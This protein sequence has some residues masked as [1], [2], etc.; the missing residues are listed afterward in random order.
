MRMRRRVGIF[1]FLLTEIHFCWSETSNSRLALIKDGNIYIGVLPDG[2][3]TRITDYQDTYRWPAVHGFSADGRKILY[4]I[5]SDEL[6][7]EK[8]I[9][10]VHPPD[11]NYFVMGVDGSD[12]RLVFSH[13]AYGVF[14]LAPDGEFVASVPCDD[15]GC[16]GSIEII[17][18]RDGATVA[19]TPEWDC[20]PT[21]ETQVMWS[22]DSK[23]IFYF[24]RIKEYFGFIEGYDQFFNLSHD[25]L[26]RFDITSS[27]SNVIADN[28]FLNG[29]PV[30]LLR[31]ASDKL[32]A[33]GSSQPIKS[34][35]PR[36][37]GIMIDP[38]T[39]SSQRM[40]LAERPLSLDPDT[41]K[42]Y[43]VDWASRKMSIIDPETGEGKELCKIETSA[44][45]HGLH[46]VR[47]NGQI[48]FTYPIEL[49]PAS[50]SK[51]A[52]YDT[53]LFDPRTN[54]RKSLRTIYP[55]CALGAIWPSS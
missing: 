10:P 4:S 24:Q 2:Q 40:D 23:A 35:E 36:F 33:W 55:G 50:E 37:F 17:R 21:D 11:R 47:V 3:P 9:Q 29:G 20:P 39:S 15:A 44:D 18:T 45:L 34:P 28:L 7:A 49:S 12:S 14:C 46:L 41:R 26:I 22:H 48:Q 31:P 53:I 51:P 32:I 38:E 54:E 16:G 1:L 43:S 19:K 13:D 25:Q 52:E 30:L 5:N 8:P 6:A 27:R 42:L